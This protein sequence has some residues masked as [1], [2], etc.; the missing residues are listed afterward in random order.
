MTTIH[1]AHPRNERGIALVITMFLMA[2]LSALVASLMFLAQTETASTRNYRTMSQARYGGEAAVHK[3]INHLLNTYTPPASF[4][5]FGTGQSPVTCTLNCGH[6]TASS[7]DGSSLSAAVSSGCIVLSGISGV[8]SNYPSTETGVAIAFNTAAQ[9]TLAANATGSTSTGGL[10][11]VNYG[12]AAI[13]I[14]MQT[15]NVYGGG[16][17]V[18]QTWQ[19]IGDGTVP[20]VQPATVEVTATLERD[21]VDAQTFAVFATGTGCGA[22]SLQGNVSTAS[23]DSS[24][25]TTVS[26]SGGNVGTNGNM[27]IGGHVDVHGS[28]SSPR[29]GVGSCTNGTGVT[30]LTESGAASVDGNNIV[31]LPQALTFPTPPL[32]S[33][34][35]PMTS[36]TTCAQMAVVLPATCAVISGKITIDPMGTTVSL[37][38]ISGNIVLKGGNYNI[39][40]IGSGNLTVQAS[41][42]GTQNV[43]VNL[44]GKTSTGDIANPFNLN[45]NAVV[46][47]SMDPSR[48]QILYAGTGSIDM[49][50]GSTAAF[51]LYAP[52]ASVTTHGNADIYGSLLAAQVTSAGTPRFIYDRHMQSTFFTMGDYV[53]SSFSWKKY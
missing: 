13:L 49:T 46:N 8:S 42:T 48:L 32:P 17:G 52:R 23:Y 43:V 24:S 6:T 44:A 40:S 2:A 5:S 47:S 26:N 10:G 36:Q 27:T 30:A 25:G 12:A 41:A 45:G 21:V 22:I 38:N 29:T 7:C 31:Q 9:G 19:I 20:G 33:P 1:P 11:T 53:M 3:A 14:S 28:L 18:I 37:G 16:T 51:M 35:P 39:N 4:G 34:L 50:G 15:V